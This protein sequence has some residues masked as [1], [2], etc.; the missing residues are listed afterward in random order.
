MRGIPVGALRIDSEVQGPL[1]TPLHRDSPY[2]LVLCIIIAQ[3]NPVEKRESSESPRRLRT[4]GFRRKGLERREVEKR[5]YGKKEAA[6][7]FRLPS[8]YKIIPG[9]EQ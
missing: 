5:I 1:G 8:E 2:R 9:F 4:G 6:H 7:G 3:K